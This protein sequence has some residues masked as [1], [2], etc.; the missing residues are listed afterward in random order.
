MMMRK[1]ITG[2]VNIVGCGVWRAFLVFLG[3]ANMLALQAEI[4]EFLRERFK[5]LSGLC[6]KGV[7]SSVVRCIDT[8]RETNTEVAIKIIRSND[9]MRKA[10]EKEAEILRRLNSTDKEGK[11]HVISLIDTFDHRGHL[12]L[13]FEAMSI[14]LR[15]LLKT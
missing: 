11:R 1:A 2:Y 4:G 15:S 12:C 9:L 7:F 14:N 6:G 10:G 13:V 3:I 5:V 8:E